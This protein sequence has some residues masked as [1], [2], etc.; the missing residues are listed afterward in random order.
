MG[1]GTATPW[2]SAWPVARVALA[3][4]KLRF[5]ACGTVAVETNATSREEIVSL[6]DTT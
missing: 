2:N 5:V 3:K 1:P 4:A 6:A